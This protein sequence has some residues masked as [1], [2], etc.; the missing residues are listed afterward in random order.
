MLIRSRTNCHPQ[1]GQQLA[2]VVQYGFTGQNIMNASNL[3]RASPMDSENYQKAMKV[4]NFYVA[5]ALQSRF[6]FTHGLYNMDLHR[7]GSWWTGK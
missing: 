4:I 3:L 6:G 5:T 2:N 1:D 7:H